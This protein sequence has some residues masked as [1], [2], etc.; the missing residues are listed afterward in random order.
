[1]VI[2]NKKIEIKE[3]VIPDGYVRVWLTNEKD[4][5]NTIAPEEGDKEGGNYFVIG[6]TYIALGEGVVFYY[7]L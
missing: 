6:N 3:I 7:D 2:A 1:M 4:F 5:F